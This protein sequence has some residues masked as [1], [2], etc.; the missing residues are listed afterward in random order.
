MPRTRN[1]HLPPVPTWTCSHCGQVHTPAALRRLGPGILECQA[2]KH[3]FASIPDKKEE[4]EPG[5][6]KKTAV[7][8]VSS[9]IRRK[10]G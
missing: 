10:S 6:L 9:T 8:A 3:P 4:P 7:S 2:C 1:K 5:G